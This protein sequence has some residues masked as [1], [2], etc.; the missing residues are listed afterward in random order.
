MTGTTSGSASAVLHALAVYAMWTGATW[1]L[2]GR[3]LTL[4]RPEAAADRMVYAVVANVLIGTLGSLWIL[5]SLL[6]RGAMSRANG[7]FAG[8]ARTAAGIAAGCILGIAF[9]VAQGAGM[10]DAIPAVNVFAQV[11]VVS[12]AEILVCWSLVGGAVEA[13]TAR[14]KLAATICAIA[15]SAILFGV[16]HVA[17]SPPFDEVG[18]VVRLT[19]VGVA[20]GAFF[21][22]SR[23]LYGTLLF[24]NFLATYGVLQA[25]K[26]S[27]KLDSLSVLQ[28]RLLATAASAIFLLAAFDF[29]WVRRLSHRD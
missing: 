8:P 19:G 25:L 23:D 24:H 5:R 18:M 28:P 9:L 21:F 27:G 1:L 2:E 4:Q 6:R 12:A 26:A 14:W 13:S 17:H 3:I 16:Y 22:V 29:L 7:G 11:L 10:A 15:G 20:T